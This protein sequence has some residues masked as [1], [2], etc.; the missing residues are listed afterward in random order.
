M[1]RHHIDIPILAVRG[2]HDLWQRKPFRYP[3]YWQYAE[4]M[5]H[6]K[7]WFAEFNIHHLENNPFVIDDVLIAGFDG[8]Y[9]VTNP[10][11]NDQEMVRFKDVEG[12]P[13]MSYLSNKAYKDLDGVLALDDSPYRASVLV[14]HHPPFVDDPFWAL[15][16][17]NPNY[18]QP[19]KDK[20]DVLCVGHSHQ[21]RD[22]IED[23]CRILN[24]GAKYNS[25]PRKIIFEV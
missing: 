21:Y 2:N 23:G 10:P 12:C 18:L 7:E 8:W 13:I 24:A 15:M 3:S 6:H 5:R 19:I 4:M 17:A 11:S 14:T 16:S 25:V 9:N 22:D 1:F 20:F